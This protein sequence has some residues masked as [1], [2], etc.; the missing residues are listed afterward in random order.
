M[1]RLRN[2]P[3]SRRRAEVV[4]NI[5]SIYAQEG[6]AAH[7]LAY[8]ILEAR[9][10]GKLEP[11]TF[12]LE[13]DFLEAIYVYVAHVD[14]LSKFP[15]AVQLLEHRF[16]LNSVYPGCFGTVDCV[17]YLP[18]DR[19]L[20]VTD[21]KHGGGVFVDVERNDQLMYYALGAI[22]AFPSWD[23]QS[24]RLEIVQPRYVGQGE[25]IRKWDTT[26]KEL[27]VFEQEVKVICKASEPYDAPLAAGDW[28]KFCPVAGADACPLLKEER[29]ALA[30]KVF[31]DESIQ[32]VSIDE[33]AKQLAWVPVFQAQFKLMHELAYGLAMK[34]QKIPGWKLVEKESRREYIDKEEAHILMSDEYGIKIRHT[35]D[36]YLSPS[37]VETLP[38][39]KRNGH[40]KKQLQ[41]AMVTLTKRSSAGFALVRED[42]G[43]DEMKKIEAKTV[44]ASPVDED[45]LDVFN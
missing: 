22:K 26:P 42:D 37:Q 21:Y 24:I 15:G 20:V 5:S 45:E 14:E 3:G 32:E 16:D 35:K 4:P 34:G 8:D 6:T 17:T 30:R 7:A 12:G 38:T 18:R 27:A 10:K 31:K 43:R 36:V 25:L 44:F 2:C 19:T 9:S 13:E 28:C 29:K 41:E 33:L 1:K 23:I 11:D 39:E 40:T